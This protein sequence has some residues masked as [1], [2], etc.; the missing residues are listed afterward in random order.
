MTRFIYVPNLTL[1]MSGNTEC[2][3]LIS[4]DVLVHYV[5]VTTSMA[6]DKLCTSFM[7][8]FSLKQYVLLRG[9]LKATPPKIT[10]YG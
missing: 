9:Y 4:K 5:S 6:A 7:C 2:I 10:A 8:L 1:R 3:M